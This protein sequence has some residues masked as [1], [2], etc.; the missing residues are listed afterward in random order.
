MEQTQSVE[1]AI[2]AALRALEEG[3]SLARSMAKSAS[4]RKQSQPEKRFEERAREKME[5]AA[6]LRKLLVERREPMTEEKVV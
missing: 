3:A 1:N 5:Q 2:W 6:L 4:G